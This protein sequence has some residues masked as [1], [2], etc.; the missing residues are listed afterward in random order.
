VKQRIDK[1]QL[2]ELTPEQQDKL[3]YLW[4]PEIGHFIYAKQWDI[5]EIIFGFG[6]DKKLYFSDK[7]FLFENECL[8]LLSVGQLLRLLDNFTEEPSLKNENLRLSINRTMWLG[9][10]KLVDALFQAVKE[11]L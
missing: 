6:N 7:K 5:E 8:P 2:L 9:N 10:S 11:I 1:S 4:E 3:R